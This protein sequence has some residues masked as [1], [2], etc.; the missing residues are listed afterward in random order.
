MHKPVIFRMYLFFILFLPL[1]KKLSKNWYF[2][3]FNSVLIRID[4]Q[5]MRQLHDLILQIWLMKPYD[6]ITFKTQH[7]SFTFH[8]QLSH[9]FRVESIDEVGLCRFLLHRVGGKPFILKHL[10]HCLQD[11]TVRAEKFRSIQNPSLL[12]LKGLV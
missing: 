4:L 1:V 6:C 2:C 11:Q 10:K 9:L 12:T 7:K 8:L 5:L 3:V